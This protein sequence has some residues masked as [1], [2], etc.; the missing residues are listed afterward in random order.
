MPHQEPR[1]RLCQEIA[2]LVPS[3]KF[4]REMDRLVVPFLVDKVSGHSYEC[5]TITFGSPYIMAK[6]EL[7]SVSLI[8]R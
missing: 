6:G 3:D 8:K 1:N 7:P 4:Q 2:K 5:V